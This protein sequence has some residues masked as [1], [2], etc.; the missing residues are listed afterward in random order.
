MLENER[1]QHYYYVII[2]AGKERNKKTDIVVYV[3]P[4]V[5]NCNY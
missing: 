4:R 2:Y 3:L 1:N 5:D